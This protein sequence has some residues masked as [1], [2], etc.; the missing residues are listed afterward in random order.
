[1]EIILFTLV[2]IFLYIF[3]D[4]LL[5]KLEQRRGAHFKNRSLIYF[6]II[7]ILTLGTFEVLQ[8]FLQQSGGS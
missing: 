5:R 4:W 8:H 3:A 1:M 6:V 7:L 2:A